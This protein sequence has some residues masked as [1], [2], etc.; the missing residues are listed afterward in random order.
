MTGHEVLL[1]VWRGDKLLREWGGDTFTTNNY[2][3]LPSGDLPVDQKIVDG[4][5][6]LGMLRGGICYDGA[7][8]LNLTSKGA[9]EIGKPTTKEMNTVTDGDGNAVDVKRRR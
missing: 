1:M 2:F 3:R 8:L 9:K 6:G 7:S 4:L 5:L